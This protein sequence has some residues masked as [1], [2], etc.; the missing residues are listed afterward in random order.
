VFL[1]KN[2]GL[3]TSA[4]LDRRL[5][6]LVGD[7]ENL[8]LIV[9][10]SG[11]LDSQVLLSLLSE[12]RVS[13]PFNLRAI[14]IHHGINPQADDWAVLCQ[15]SC[16]ALAIKLDIFRV[17]VRPS[18]AGIEAAARK[19]RYAELENQLHSRSDILLT[20]HHQDDQ[21]ETL[22]L[23]LVRGSGVSGLAAMPAVR[24][25]GN[26]LLC[27]PL[28]DISRQ[29]L[30]EYADTRKLDWVSDESN[31][32][33]EI[34]RSFLR[35]SVLP[36]L[37]HHWPQVTTT[38]ARTASH[39]A[40]ANFLLSELAEE[41]IVKRNARNDDKLMLQGLAD[42]SPERLGNILRYWI[43]QQGVPAP[44]VRQLAEI[45]RLVNEPP[46]TSQAVVRWGRFAACLYRKQLQ[47]TSG[48]PG[49]LSGDEIS[50][51]L[52]SGEPLY[53]GSAC[54]TAETA[55]G[56]GLAKDRVGSNLVIRFRRGGER[57]K[58]PGRS[59]H[60][61]LKNLFQEQGIPSWERK[62]I[63]LI[64]A[65]DH[66]AAIGDRWMCEPYAARPGEPA[67]SLKMSEMLGK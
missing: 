61:S 60:T 31:S 35:V 8:N 47:L 39:M 53:L 36:R 34:R 43:R 32:D 56:F 5:R 48:E 51:N 19:A 52:L 42:L 27:R 14:H 63:P 4:S 20:A 23:N 25:I 11:G 37:Q 9:A 65:G 30:Q 17:S 49:Q 6:Q 15:A 50:W 62:T 16:D 45:V 64:Y 18:K 41:D 29:Q 40:E 33:L 22:L 24:A 7:Y 66:L 13:K 46:H 67:W 2:N 21:A 28:L 59:H 38:L 12:L 55:E 57:C 58:L 1:K 26:G 10:Y 3:V 44:S 54:L